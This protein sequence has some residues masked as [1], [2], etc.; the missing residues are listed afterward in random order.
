MATK[1]PQQQSAHEKKDK[2]KPVSPWT[3]LIVIAIVLVLITILTLAFPRLHTTGTKI[4]VSTDANASAQVKD[5][6]AQKAQKYPRATE[7]VSPDYYHN[8]PDNQT[9]I[10]IQSLVG[11]KVILVDFWTYSCINCQRT[12]PYLNDWYA[13]Y[14]S[15]GLEII[16]VHTPEF[17]FEHDQT[18]VKNA[19]KQYGIKYPV[20]QDNE[21]QTWNAYGNLYWPHEYLIDIDGF[22][23]EEHIGEGGYND[24]EIEIQKLLAERA[25]RL[26]DTSA[27]EQLQSAS[28]NLTQIQEN[29]S[30]PQIGTQEIYAG[31]QFDRGQFGNAEGHV[32]GAT[33]NYSLP[34]V[35]QPNIFYLSG[36]WRNDPQAMVAEGDGATSPT[37][38]SAKN[39]TTNA[40]I[41]RA[42]ITLTYT[43]K[44][45]NIV[46]GL[47]AGITAPQT[48]QLT[49][50]GEPI[51]SINVSGQGLYTLMDASDYATHTIQITAPKGLQFYTFTFG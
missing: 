27:S 38:S 18:N 43:A 8:L 50:D 48:V 19:I 1:K 32:P 7:L 20:V 36:E 14:A 11:K 24:T 6:I 46:A 44:Q 16:G 17:D 47:D 10:T 39:N 41:A 28:N 49:L 4:V 34:L 51:P 30:F 23:V 12:I 25:Q 33:I 37:D 29:I 40:T 3:T 26:N 35:R 21:Y 15:Q 2:S 9:N 31:Y 22:V 13:K 42:A 5:I 45:I